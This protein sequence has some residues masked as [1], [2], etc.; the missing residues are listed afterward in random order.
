MKF[1]TGAR[2]S[3]KH[4]GNFEDRDYYDMGVDG[5]NTAVVTKSGRVYTT[6]EWKDSDGETHQTTAFTS[7]LE[8]AQ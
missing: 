4:G 5:P 6:L 3:Y 1:Q 8:L 2:V 7:D